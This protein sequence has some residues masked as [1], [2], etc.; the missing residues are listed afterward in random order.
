M[1]D[2]VARANSFP[3]EFIAEV[4]ARTPIASV[5]GRD[6]PL[7]RQGGQWSG[8]CPFHGERRPSFYVYPDHYHCFGCGAHGDAFSYLIASRGMTF[9]DAVNDLAAE[10]GMI[11]G[12]QPSGA[13][14]KKP[15][16]PIA[17]P[18][19][20][21]TEARRAAALAMWLHARPDVL[22]TPVDSYLKNRGIDLRAMGHVPGVLRFAPDL[23]HAG[24]HMNL[25]A[26]VAAITGPDGRHAATH[27]TWLER[28][29]GAWIKA[30][31]TIN[32][33]PDSKKVL[34]SFPGGC[35]RLWK[36]ASGKSLKAAP[37][38][39]PVVIAEGI[40]TSL[41][42]VQAIPEIRVLCGV[43]QGSMAN[44][45]L[46]PQIGTVILALDN[47]KKP[48]AE[49]NAARLVNRWMERGFDVRIARSP[50]GK[51]FNDVLGG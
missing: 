29:G 25:P 48:A 43:S 20:D 47:D 37:P 18:P 41:S 21:D 4:R 38:G 23:W 49:Q 44:V 39:D 7:K 2:T 40:E 15:L 17:A 5:I 32:G 3:P 36:G 6:V 46:P 11:T 1:R 42:I 8:C 19:P 31:L 33:K 27:R 16:A 50:V 13:E 26:M 45:E 22:D 9:V 34:G 28:S 14:P 10:A 12:H 30:R 24:A 51:D 35:I